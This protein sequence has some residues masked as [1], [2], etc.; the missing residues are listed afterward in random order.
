MGWNSAGFEIGNV[1][2]RRAYPTARLK[3]TGPPPTGIA[4]DDPAG[5]LPSPA[6]TRAVQFY[7]EVG[8][9]QRSTRSAGPFQ[10]PAIVDRVVT[11]S[12]P[13]AANDNF[14][15]FPGYSDARVE[16]SLVAT[17]VAV[18]WPTWFERLAIQG[19][20]F[21][22]N[23]RGIWNSVGLTQKVNWDMP[24]KGIVPLTNWFLTMTVAQIGGVAGAAWAGYIVVL[25][26]VSR[27]A[28]ALYAG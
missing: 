15:L 3:R 9:N 2:D 19:A 16:E 4:V 26:G 18:S 20:D 23:T 24:V 6:R 8:A 7:I 28:L 27:E 11:V 21:G 12:D 13:I 10:G 22:V 5:A 17:T 14:C 1:L 25:E